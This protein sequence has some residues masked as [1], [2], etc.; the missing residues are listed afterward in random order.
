LCISGMVAGGCSASSRR[1]ISSSNNRD[2]PNAT[3]RSASHSARSHRAATRSNCGI[4][5][6]HCVALTGVLCIRSVSA[7]AL[8]KMVQFMK[9]WHDKEYG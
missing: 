1:S 8:T 9:I 4:D 2:V 3:T 5:G 6:H 7:C